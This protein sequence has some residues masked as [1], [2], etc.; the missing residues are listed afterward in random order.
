VAKLRERQA[1]ESG[2]L[3]LQWP[4]LPGSATAETTVG[5]KRKEEESSDSERNEA[6]D[7]L[8]I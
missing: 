8:H 2:A 5:L 3:V 6:E 7:L 1:S 4:R